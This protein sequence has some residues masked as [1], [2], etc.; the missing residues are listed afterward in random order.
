MPFIKIEPCRDEIKLALVANYLSGKFGYDK[1]FLI[2]TLREMPLVVGPFSFQDINTISGYL[3]KVGVNVE[4][5]L[6]AKEESEEIEEERGIEKERRWEGE[7]GGE[8]ISEQRLEETE[9]TWDIW[10]KAIL[11]P[12]SVF[13]SRIGVKSAIIIGIVMVSFLTASTS[14][15]LGVP[16]IVYEFLAK[17][18]GLLLTTVLFRF[19][20]GWG[21]TPFAEILK[22]VFVSTSCLIFVPIPY[23]NFIAGVLGTIILLFGI[24]SLTE[25]KIRIVICLAFSPYIPFFF[26]K[27]PC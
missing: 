21:K 26:S 20:T 27:F 18:I 23:G 13:R 14:Y 8:D 7:L 16:N 12:H 5:E 6:R 9:P 24:S 11:T 22:V 3:R 25:S 15:C 10:I 19:I 1:E 2:E 4:V 17:I